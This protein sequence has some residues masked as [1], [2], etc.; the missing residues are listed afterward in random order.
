MVLNPV[1]RVFLKP[2]SKGSG[3]T[4]ERTARRS[5]GSLTNLDY[6]TV[7]KNVCATSSKS[8]CSH[9]CTL[10]LQI[11]I[12]INIIVTETNRQRILST[13]QHPFISIPSSYELKIPINSNQFNSIMPMTTRIHRQAFIKSIT[14]GILMSLLAL[15]FRLFF[16]RRRHSP[17]VP[18]RSSN[19]RRPEPYR[20]P[21]WTRSRTN[22]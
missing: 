18:P 4:P 19:N 2:K 12:I 21:F 14:G 20:E 22:Q 8:K 6:A 13:R 10:Y 9:F 15:L 1:P 3:V 16:G 11:R 5:G 17:T 7:N